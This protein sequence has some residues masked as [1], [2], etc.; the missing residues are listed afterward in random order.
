MY[1]VW[2]DDAIKAIQVVREKFPNMTTFNSIEGNAYGDFVIKTD[3]SIYIVK[4]TDFSI[5]Y[6][7]G[8]WKNNKWVKAV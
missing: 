1:S 3:T 8:D 2:F 6:S 4:H 5:W 7:T